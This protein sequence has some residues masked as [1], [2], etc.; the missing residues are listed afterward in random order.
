MA[1]CEVASPN[2]RR[3]GSRAGEVRVGP[4]LGQRADDERLAGAR[5]PDQRLDPGAGGEHAA[6]GGGLVDAELD[7]RTRRSC[8]TNRCATSGAAA[9]RRRRCGGGGEQSALG[10]H[11]VGGGVQP[12]ARGLVGRV[13]VAQPQLRRARASS[14]GRA[15]SSALGVLEGFG[16][17]LVEQLAD[18]G[19]VGDAEVVGQRGVDRAGRGRRGSSRP[20]AAAR[21]PARSRSPPAAT[22]PAARACGAGGQRGARRRR[23]GPPAMSARSCASTRSST[24]SRVSPSCDFA[25]RVAQRGLPG[26]PVELQRCSAP[27]RTGPRTPSTS[28]AAFAVTFG[29]RE[30]IRSIASGRDPDDLAGLAVRAGRRPAPRARG[31][32]VPRWSA[33]R[34]PPRPAATGAGCARRAVRHTPSGPSHPVEDRVVDVQLRVVVAGVVLEERRRPPSRARRPSGPAAPP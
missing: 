7:A 12:R 9:P 6:D 32:A 20:C 26:Q 21:R 17:E 25:R 11:V 22:T 15:A 28:S 16:G 5:R 34:P 30:E 27:G 13:A 29:R 31:S 10:A 14:P 19:A 23:P 3:G 2:T 18:V 8:R 33:R 1:I 24:C 4:R